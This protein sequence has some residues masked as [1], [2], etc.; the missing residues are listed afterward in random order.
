MPCFSNYLVPCLVTE[1]TFDALCAILKLV[2]ATVLPVEN[3]LPVASVDNKILQSGLLDTSISTT[4]YG[5]AA[6]QL[7]QM[8]RLSCKSYK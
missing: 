8:F 7:L 3:S 1:D 4:E 6:Q 5:A 2:T